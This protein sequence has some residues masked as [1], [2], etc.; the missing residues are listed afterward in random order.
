[1]TF[2]SAGI[3]LFVFGL[4][5]LYSAKGGNIEPIFYFLEYFNLYSIENK[6]EHLKTSVF[7]SKLMIGVALIFL[8][9]HFIYY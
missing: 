5:W 6:D 2:L 4:L 1:M 9:L 3:I 7:L 8:V